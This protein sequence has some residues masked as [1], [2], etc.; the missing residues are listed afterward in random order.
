M[1]HKEVSDYKEV[2]KVAVEDTKIARIYSS[3][4]AP[5]RQTFAA[6]FA[7]VRVNN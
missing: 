1:A 6:I 4:L 5:G 3:Y 2:V 7:V